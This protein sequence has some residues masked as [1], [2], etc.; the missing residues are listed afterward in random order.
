MSFCGTDSIYENSSVEEE[1]WEVIHVVLGGKF[2]IPE[3]L[4]EPWKDNKRGNNQLT[5]RLLLN[6]RM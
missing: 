5:G 6:E 2:N 4:F 3:L 1:F